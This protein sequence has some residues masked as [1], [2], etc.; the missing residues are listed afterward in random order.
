DQVFNSLLDR[1]VGA[2]LVIADPLFLVL[3]DKLINLAAHHAIPTVYYVREY[4]ANGGLMSYGTSIPDAMRQC[5]NYVGRILKGDKPADLPVLQPTK[6]ELVINLQV[7]K[8]LG[9]AIPA[10]L[11]AR[12][13]DVIE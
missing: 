6:F 13:D 2:L 7:A 4:P 9:L 10:A 5:G 3:R 1:K 12:A 11:L 8:T